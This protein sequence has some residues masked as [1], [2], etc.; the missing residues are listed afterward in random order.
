MTPP[1]DVV[2]W[3]GTMQADLGRAVVTLAS[4]SSPRGTG[5][6]MCTTGGLGR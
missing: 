2:A 1:E 3:L 5:A 4:R 6:P